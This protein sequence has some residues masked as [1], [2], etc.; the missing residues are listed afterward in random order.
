MT[1]L[2]YTLGIDLGLA[3]YEHGINLWQHIIHTLGL[4]R[5]QMLVTHTLYFF[6]L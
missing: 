1:C 3:F 2:L 5:A 6:Y 4:V